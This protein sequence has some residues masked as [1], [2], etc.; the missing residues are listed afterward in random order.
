MEIPSC[1]GSKELEEVLVNRI[2]D[3]CVYKGSDVATLPGGDMQPKVFPRMSVPPKWWRWKAIV[4]TKLVNRFGEEHIN[5]LELR[6]YLS[7]L[8]W[9][10]RRG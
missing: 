6:A 3:G 5:V 1:E 8:R 7:M 4:K 10:T 9:R 2:S